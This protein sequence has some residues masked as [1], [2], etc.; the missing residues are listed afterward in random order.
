[1]HGTTQAIIIRKLLVHSA[2]QQAKVIGQPLLEQ[3]LNC[4]STLAIAPRPV[5]ALPLRELD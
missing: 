3:T 1:L 4:R 2:L 5:G